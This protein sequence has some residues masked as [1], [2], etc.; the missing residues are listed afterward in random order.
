M[1]ILIETIKDGFRVSIPERR[2]TWWVYPD[3]HEIRNNGARY[4]CKREI[5]APRVNLPMEWKLGDVINE[6][7]RLYDTEKEFYNPDN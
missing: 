4:F 7:V 5:V 2:W 6:A 1:N 3:D